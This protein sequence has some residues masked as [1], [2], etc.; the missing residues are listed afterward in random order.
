MA[1]ADP[2]TFTINSVANPLPR[3]GSGLGSGSF[4]K[5]D[6]LVKATI[7]HQTVQKTGRVRR[8]LRLDHSKIAEDPFQGSVNAKYSMGMYIVIDVPPVGYTIAEQKQVLDAFT[9]FLATSGNATK[10]L[11]GE[12]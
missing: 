7:A 4:S 5:D 3:V 2:I 1:F 9:A 6:G 8:Q 10:L 12:A 11:G